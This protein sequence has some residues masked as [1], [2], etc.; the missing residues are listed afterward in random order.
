VGSLDFGS[1]LEVLAPTPK[2]ISAALLGNLC[3]FS[4]ARFC[5][6]PTVS[7]ERNFSFAPQREAE[8]NQIQ[9]LNADCR[10]CRNS[11][12]SG[13][14][15][16]TGVVRKSAHHFCQGGNRIRVLYTAAA[17]MSSSSSTHKRVD[18]CADLGASRGLH[19]PKRLKRI[20]DNCRRIKTANV[21]V[22]DD[23]ASSFHVVREEAGIFRGN[24]DSLPAKPEDLH[25]PANL[26]LRRRKPTKSQARFCGIALPPIFSL[27][28]GSG[29]IRSKGGCHFRSADRGIVAARFPQHRH[30]QTAPF[31][32]KP[33]GTCVTRIRQTRSALMTPAQSPTGESVH[34]LSSYF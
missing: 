1:A 10:A 2:S 30:S 11:A 9:Q 32:S 16:K 4:H 18:S 23:M 25:R 5:R 31:P 13:A 19:P 15:R 7:R 12:Q 3:E 29:K 33:S 28:H 6:S 27:V 21:S 34:V 20:S 26:S 14:S 17:T 8:E 22:S 24:W